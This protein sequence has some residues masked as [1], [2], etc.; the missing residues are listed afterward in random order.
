MNFAPNFK[1][2]Q[3]TKKLAETD[4]AISRYLIHKDNLKVRALIDTRRHLLALVNLEITAAEMKAYDAKSIYTPEPGLVN[5]I[6]VWCDRIKRVKIRTVSYQSSE[7][8]D[9][10]L[11][12]ILPKSWNFDNDVII[13]HQPQS[14]HLFEAVQNRG[15]SHILCYITGDVLPPELKTFAIKNKIN[16]STSI[17]DL[18]RTVSLL[19]TRAQSVI[20]I[21]C[22]QDTARAKRAK[23]A[24]TDAVTAGKRTRIENTATASKFGK[25]WA[26]NLL[27]NMPK[28][29]GIKNLHQLCI[30]GV[31]DAVIVA[32]GPSLNKNIDQLRDIQDKVFIITA[33]RS[34]PVLD[35]AGIEPDLVVQLDAEDDKVAQELSPDPLHPIKNL[36]LEGTVNPGFFAMP[37]KN[38]IWSLPQH[39]FDVHKKF[40]TLPTPFNVPSVS[41]YGLCLCQFLNFKNIC[42][43]GQDLAAS[44]GKQYAD[45]AT[46]LLPAH[47]SMSMFQIAV[48]GFYGDTVMTRASYE[49]QIKRCSEIAREWRS[50]GIGINLV[51]ATEGGAHIPEFDHM[52]LKNFIKQR[53]LQE[54]K[55][56]KS[57]DF[58]AEFPITA[59]GL[60]SYSRNVHKIMT[61]ISALADMIIKLDNKVEKTIGIQKKTRKVIQKFKQLN[62]TTSLLQIAMQ[63]GIAKVIGTSRTTETVDSYAKFFVKIKETADALADATKP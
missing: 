22:D 1:I 29:Q 50:H 46:D 25:S 42:F 13:I 17:E 33:L 4:S 28:L 8:C 36:L 59:D 11:D 14:I 51:N 16:I 55:T 53:Q 38:I 57:L 41:I 39:F 32:S 10:M 3:L 56:N 58:S 26:L 15:Q 61:R 7:F 19:Q 60:E 31:E 48:P 21:S 62:D 27:K 12:H 35:A 30:N 18:E 34:L 5:Q 37:A 24:I 47:A 63:D 45:G 49:Y 40:G 52:T 2:E 43:I 54:K 44:S 23:A 9:L 20:S 6:E